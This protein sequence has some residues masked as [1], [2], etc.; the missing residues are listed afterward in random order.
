MA[1]RGYIAP[2][3]IWGTKTTP[4]T[5]PKDSEWPSA[6][7]NRYMRLRLARL[8]NEGVLPFTASTLAAIRLF[9]RVSYAFCQSVRVTAFIYVGL[10]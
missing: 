4:V 8:E 9:A 1:H 5:T 10:S 6:A 3:S 2:G 7:Q